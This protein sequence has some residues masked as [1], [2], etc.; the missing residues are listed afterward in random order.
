MFEV[1]ECPTS[2]S[3]CENQSPPPLFWPS[4]SPPQLVAHL[5]ALPL[6]P[7][8]SSSQP[9]V[10]PHSATY[11]SPGCLFTPISTLLISSFFYPQTRYLQQALIQTVDPTYI[12]YIFSQIHHIVDQPSIGTTVNTNLLQHQGQ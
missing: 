8:L 2:K 12:H 7:G 4:A 1:K 11:P 9:P 3:I 10:L 6:P 5:L